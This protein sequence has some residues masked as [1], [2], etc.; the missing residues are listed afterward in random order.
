MYLDV[1]E[2]TQCGYY[3]DPPDPGLIVL[4]QRGGRGFVDIGANVGFFSLLASKNFDF[5][6]GFEVSN[7][8]RRLLMNNLEMNSINNVVVY[9]KGLSDVSGSVTL[10]HNPF[11]NGGASLEGGAREVM[12]RD[13]SYVWSA[14]DVKVDRLDNLIKSDNR[15]IIDFIKIDVE[16]HEL[17]VIRGGEETIRL[18]RPLI[19]A[20]V[21]KSVV[22]VKEII[23]TLPGLYVPYSLIDKRIIGEGGDVPDDVLFIPSEKVFEIKEVFEK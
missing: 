13:A 16:G 8:T 4:I 5:V 19:Y 3:F 20:E 17:S 21:S 12:E 2:F 22:K 14:E 18:Y 10:Y 7:H 23:N 6:H 9:D 1:N 11:N 15:G